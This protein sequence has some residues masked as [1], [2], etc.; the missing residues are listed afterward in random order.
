MFLFPREAQP[1]KDEALVKL[2]E[3]R[4]RVYRMG[5]KNVRLKEKS[6]IRTPS[7]RNTIP[8]ES[9]LG[10]MLKSWGDLSCRRER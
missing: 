9:P 4:P 8:P 7:S 5:N 10:R 3:E 6:G 1:E 2:L